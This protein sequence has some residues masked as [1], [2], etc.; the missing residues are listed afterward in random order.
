MNANIIKTNARFYCSP[1]CA[2][3]NMALFLVYCLKISFKYSFFLPKLQ[4]YLFKN[5]L[6]ADKKIVNLS[7]A[8]IFTVPCRGHFF[9][10]DSC[11]LKQMRYFEILNISAYFFFIKI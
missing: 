11:P 3:L 1:I 10:N 7:P 2:F 5:M 9:S 8:I 6:S 4:Y